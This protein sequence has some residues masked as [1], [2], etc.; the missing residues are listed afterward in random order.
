MQVCS[1]SGVSRM[2]MRIIVVSDSSRWLQE[3]DH[4]GSSAYRR[5]F[6]G[7]MSCC[8]NVGLEGDQSFWLRIVILL[9]LYLA[10]IMAQ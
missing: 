5:A 9:G 10:T 6:G 7:M 3:G 1:T 4:C 2:C 8:V